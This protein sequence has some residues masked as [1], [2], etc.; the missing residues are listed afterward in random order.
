ML[1]HF[2]KV[3][4]MKHKNNKITQL[5]KLFE[6]KRCVTINDICTELGGSERTAKRYLASFT[7]YSSYTHNRKW[8]TIASISKFNREGLWAYN[9]IFFSKYGTL[10]NTILQ[11]LDESRS[12]LTSGEL[13]QK[14]GVACY[15]VLNQFHKHGDLKRIKTGRGFVYLSKNADKRK[16]QLS[17]LATCEVLSPQIAILVLIECIKRPEASFVEI[18]R[19][20]LQQN[21]AVSGEV[22]ER[23]L[24]SHHLKKL[25]I[26][27]TVFTFIGNNFRCT[28]VRATSLKR[29]QQ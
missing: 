12:G 15:S 25:L 13:S 27:L 2:E 14:L 1:C 21:M 5:K 7:Y 22:I 17:V 29:Y 9:S 24:D 18:S 26:S 3:E 10:K 23:F 20:L 4:G 16:Q 28:T 6:Q 19:A 11:Y 8:Y